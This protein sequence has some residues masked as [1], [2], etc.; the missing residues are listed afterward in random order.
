MGGASGELTE[1]PIR[2]HIFAS[3][4]P[5]PIPGQASQ[6]AALTYIPGGDCLCGPADWHGRPGGRGE[7]SF[8]AG[9]SSW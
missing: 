5:P 1:F 8:R 7:G 3:P 2:F 6:Q 4:V 9:A